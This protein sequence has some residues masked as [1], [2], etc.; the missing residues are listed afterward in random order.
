MKDSLKKLESFY[1]NK[2]YDRG[3]VF[4]D[5]LSEKLEPSVYHYNKGTFLAKKES[6][7][8]A[9]LHFERAKELNFNSTALENNLEVVKK[10]LQVEVIEEPQ[11]FTENLIYSFDGL[12][13]DYFLSFF[14]IFIIL[15]SIF[16]K[17]FKSLSLAFLFLFCSLIP[18]G[19]SKY[20]KTVYKR[21]IVTDSTAV[22][23]GPSEVFEQ[24]S[25]IPEGVKIIL[26]EKR[27]NNWHYID[28]PQPYRGWVK[29]NASTMLKGNQDVY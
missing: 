2:E 17:K 6:F 23:D 18:L 9:R 24:I 8:K 25:E 27:D 7:A 1:V 12:S 14:L 11:S 29:L 5:E 15:S 26:S 20:L 22:F 13:K 16:F 21:A 4:L 3:L 19:V 28:F 10:N